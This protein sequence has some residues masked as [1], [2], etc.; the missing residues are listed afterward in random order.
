[1]AGGLMDSVLENSINHG[2]KNNLKKAMEGAG[3]KVTSDTGLWQYP[4]IIRKKMAV[5]TVNGI[6][7]IGGDCIKIIPTIENDI[8][9]YEITTSIET[10]KLNR[11]TWANP[12]NKW[13]KDFTVQTLFDDLFANILPNIRGVYAGDITLSD[14]SGADTKEWKNELFGVSGWKTGLKPSSRYLRLYLTSQHEPLYIHM[15]SYIEEITGGYNVV[16]SDTVHFIIDDNN[17]KL[18]AHISVIS[19]EQLKSIGVIDTI[20]KETENNENTDTNITQ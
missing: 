4:D 5:N 8:I 1:M 16:D 15:N 9:N 14:Y 10:Y 18:S 20:V 7:L 12:N 2:L 13:D 19:D 17:H 3:V 6:N 11:P